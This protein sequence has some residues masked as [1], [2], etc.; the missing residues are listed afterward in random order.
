M[1]SAKSDPTLDRLFRH[2]A[3]ANQ[4]MFQKLRAVPVESLALCAENEERTVSL[5]LEHLVRSAGNYGARVLEEP[6]GWH[7]YLPA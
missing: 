2:M 5:I 4:L 7:D 1:D 3:W 6:T